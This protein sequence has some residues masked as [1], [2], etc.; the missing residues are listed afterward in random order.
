M[1]LAADYAGWTREMRQYLTTLR[2]HGIAVEFHLPGDD[3]PL[4]GSFL[5]ESRESPAEADACAVTE[6]HFEDLGVIAIT[7][8]DGRS[9]ENYYP[10]MPRGLN[11]IHAQLRERVPRGDTIAFPGTILY[12]ETTRRLRPDSGSQPEPRRQSLNDS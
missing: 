11:E 5:T 7:F 12:D 3:R 10:L 2:A 9:V 6:H 1:G 8:A 4:Q